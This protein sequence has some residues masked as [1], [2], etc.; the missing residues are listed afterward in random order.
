MVA[1]IAQ[2]LEADQF[3]QEDKLTSLELESLMELSI[4]ALSKHQEKVSKAPA[5]VF[6][7]T[8]RDIEQ[9][10]ATT[11]IDVFR[12]I[13]GMNV[14]RVNSTTSNVSIRG[15][16][17]TFAWN[18]LVLVDGRSI[19]S[20]L[21]QGVFWEQ[22][23]IPLASIDRIE[24]VRGPGG[25][26]WGA[27]AVNGVVNIITKS[28][29][30]DQGTTVSVYGGNQEYMLDSRAGSLV[31]DDPV[32]DGTW[33]AY[34]NYQHHNPW[35][36]WPDT[37]S[38]LFRAGVRWDGV[39]HNQYDWSLMLDHYR[40]DTQQVHRL[41]DVPT[42]PVVQEVPVDIDGYALNASINAEEYNHYEWSL[43]LTGEYYERDLMPLHRV[44]QWI[45]DLSFQYRQDSLFG[46]LTLGAN[47]R[48]YHDQYDSTATFWM[49][50][51]SEY[52]YYY[53]VFVQ[54]KVPFHDDTMA[55]ILGTKFEDHRFQGGFNQPTVRY[56]WQLSPMQTFWAAYSVSKQAAG[57]AQRGLH[58]R[59]AF[60]PAFDPTQYGLEGFPVAPGVHEINGE[61]G[62][63]VEARVEAW[64][65]GYRIYA[66]AN[67]SLDLSAYY[68]E[69]DDIYLVPPLEL[70]MVDNEY[71]LAT[72]YFVESGEGVSS[73]ADLVIE[74]Q[75]EQNDWRFALG[76][77]GIDLVSRPPYQ[78]ELGESVEDADPRWQVMLEN[79][80]RFMPRWNLNT[81]VRYTSEAVYYDVFESVDAYTTV[82]MKLL[83]QHSPDLHIMAAVKNLTDASHLEG[84]IVGGMPRE[85]EEVPRSVILGF[86]LNW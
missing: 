26:I 69:Y 86:R 40:T 37:S 33:R 35:S 85:E 23:L 42:Q 16:N 7:L 60:D 61:D 56:A 4:S 21:Y 58:W 78:Y 70:E 81:L 2:G 68:N 47:Y 83:Y 32:G 29:R 49:N 14:A 3:Q 17:T 27:N 5:A 28:S 9:S 39:M 12:L 64:E 30:L 53:G 38:D 51:E 41:F 20:P 44:K 80:W 10:A 11:L 15:F 74:Y 8:S 62:G 67:L 79:N 36:D 31:S 25:A 76:Y 19:Y 75:T 55:L 22:H 1:G 54:Q 65:L 73:G 46:P 52:N 34:M 50:P 71:Y 59:M 6:V 77:I 66:N 13:P 72:Q 24:V 43:Q 48:A 45:G 18:M 82:D 84:R 57:R 63:M